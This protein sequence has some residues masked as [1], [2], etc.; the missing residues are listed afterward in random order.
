M[1]K[2]NFQKVTSLPGTLAANTFYF[3][4]SGA[5]AESYLTDAAGVAKSIGNT[6]MING[7][8]NAQLSGLNQIQIVATIAERNALNPTRNIQV[9]V[10]DATGDPT[11]S[12]GAATY[13]Y[14]YS[15]T[16]WVKI[17]EYESLDATV[18]WSNVSGRPTSSPG[19]IDAAVAISHSHGNKAALDKISEDG[20]GDM[21][22]NGD[23]VQKW[24]TNNW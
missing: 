7:L 15:A 1:A 21:T 6:A 20:A 13:I 8:I 4:V 10:Q 12:A 22:Y 9:L 19:A 3:V 24:Q 23:A 18:S 11:V 2:I 16:T 17:A 14:N 5:V